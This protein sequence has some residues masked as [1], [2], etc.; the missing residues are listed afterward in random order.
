MNISVTSIRWRLFNLEITVE[1]TDLVE[2]IK[3]KI[4]R[5]ENIAVESQRF[6]FK[7]RVLEDHCSLEDCKIQNGSKLFLIFEE[8][9][10]PIFLKTLQG[11]GIALKIKLSDSVDSVKEKVYEKEEFFLIHSGWSL[12]G[13]N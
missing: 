13:S 5:K 8:P 11:K 6:I 4:H 1:P 10:V 3:Q 12:Q 2:N 7:G 9:L